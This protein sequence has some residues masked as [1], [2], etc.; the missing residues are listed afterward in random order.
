[1]HLLLTYMLWTVAVEDVVLQ[2]LEDSMEQAPADVLSR[3]PSMLC[4]AALPSPAPDDS[5]APIGALQRCALLAL[6]ARQSSGVHLVVPPLHS[7]LYDVCL[8]AGFTDISGS[9]KRKDASRV[10]GKRLSEVE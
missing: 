8:S 6:E 2:S 10:F 4:V 1:M 7:A 9:W 3:Y 5:P